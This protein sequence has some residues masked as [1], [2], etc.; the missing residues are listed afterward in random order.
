[1]GR[2]RGVAE[3]LLAVAVTTAVWQLFKAGVISDAIPRMAVVIVPPLA[4]ASLLI[5]RQISRH[6][7]GGGSILKRLLTALAEALLLA[8]AVGLA[9]G[10]IGAVLFG[11]YLP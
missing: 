3:Y 5:L 4:I 8:L 1:M 7:E 10:A 2:S 9:A 11:G 6:V